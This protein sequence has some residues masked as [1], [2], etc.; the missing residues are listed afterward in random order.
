MRSS[1]LVSRS[2]QIDIN[3]FSTGAD[4][5]TVRIAL[6]CFGEEMRKIKDVYAKFQIA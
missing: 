6:R 3:T 4:G 2:P 1:V 5:A